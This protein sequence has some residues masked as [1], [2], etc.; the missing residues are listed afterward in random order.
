MNKLEKRELV[1]SF[2]IG[3]NIFWELTDE[4]L[5]LINNGVTSEELKNN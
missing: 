1:K 3:K 2:R 4:G 5:S